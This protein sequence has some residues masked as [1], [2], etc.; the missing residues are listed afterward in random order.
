MESEKLNEIRIS[1]ALSQ[2]QDDWI[3][4]PEDIRET[5]LWA[6]LLKR[7]YEM[8][9][10]DNAPDRP[11]PKE[12]TIDEFIDRL[13]CQKAVHSVEKSS[14]VEGN[15]MIRVVLNEE[16]DPN[17]VQQML[18]ECGFSWTTVTTPRPEQNSSPYPRL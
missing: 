4:E 7:G 6:D 10:K 18:S 5:M 11:A 3:M 1:N 9:L 8:C 17:S 15:A 12:E 2:V 13:N 16:E 14:Y